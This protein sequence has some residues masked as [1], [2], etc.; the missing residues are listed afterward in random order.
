MKEITLVCTFFRKCVRWMVL[1][2]LMLRC[3]PLCTCLSGYLYIINSTCS[4]FDFASAQTCTL[5]TPCNLKFCTI[6]HETRKNADNSISRQK[7][8]YRTVYKNGE[9]PLDLKPGPMDC[10]FRMIIA[11]WLKPKKMAL[12]S[13]YIHVM[14]TP[15]LFCSDKT[16]N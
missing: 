14:S 6:W 10:L 11:I 15:F 7:S 16:L 5:N 1:F 2:S 4:H 3:T 8:Q 12:D 9:T 13:F